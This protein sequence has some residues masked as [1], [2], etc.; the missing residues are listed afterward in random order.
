MTKH[1]GTSGLMPVKGSSCGIRPDPEALEITEGFDFSGAA[2]LLADVAANDDKK[3]GS[4][5]SFHADTATKE[6]TKKQD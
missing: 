3:N 4:A 1:P 2:D 6:N 5:K